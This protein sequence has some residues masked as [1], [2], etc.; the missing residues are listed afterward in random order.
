M[1]QTPRAGSQAEL[2]LSI[3]LEQAGIPFEREYRFAPPRRWRF[4]FAFL[5]APEP[6]AVFIPL[7]VEVEGGV[8]ITG[9]HT[10]GAAFEKDVEKYNAA[11][12]RGWTL[13]RYTPRMVEDGTA[14]EQICRL[15]TFPEKR[16][17]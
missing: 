4:D 3:Q 14:F 8:Y 12:E 10:R 16:V 11:T 1:S 9:R 15:L 13:L 5:E 17:A 2:L 7:A 6:G